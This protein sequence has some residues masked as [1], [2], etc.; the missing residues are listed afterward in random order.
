MQGN[1]I[2]WLTIIIVL[3]FSACKKEASE[4]TNIVDG[5][6]VP[7]GFSAVSFPADNAY[8]QARWEL[9]KKLF[10]DPALSKDSTISCGSCHSPAYAFSDTVSLS[11]GV[12]GRAG[13]R[14]SPTLANVAYLPYFTREGGVPSL[15]MQVLI[16]IQEHNE[17]DFNVL[18]ISAHRCFIS[19]FC[20][21]NFVAIN[22]LYLD[23]ITNSATF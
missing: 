9:G 11:K 8:T 18:P 21:Y 16:P 22:I 4:S 5:I 10:F 15:E 14:N 3:V 12:Q 1:H 17:F 13:T 19:Y 6:T 2:S 7:M 20:F 23:E